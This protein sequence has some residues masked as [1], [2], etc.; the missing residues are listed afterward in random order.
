MIDTAVIVSALA[1]AFVAA[2]AADLTRY[3]SR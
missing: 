3:R 1:L 2:F